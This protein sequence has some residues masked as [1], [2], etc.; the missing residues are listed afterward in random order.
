MSW[1]RAGAGVAEGFLDGDPGTCPS[2][3]HCPQPVSQLSMAPPPTTALPC[4]LS[5]EST[6]PFFQTAPQL[7]PLLHHGPI[8]VSLVHP[9]F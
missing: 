2:S 3:R 8:G 9:K 5:W 4:A 1:G 6:Y 7:Q